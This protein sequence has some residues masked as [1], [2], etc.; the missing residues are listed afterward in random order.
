[1]KELLQKIAADAKAAAKCIEEE[2][3]EDWVNKLLDIAKTAEEELEK[4]DDEPADESDN[5]WEAVDV[6]KT[7]EAAVETALKKYVD[8]YITA[9]D[10][11][12]LLKDLMDAF[13][14]EVTKSVKEE[15]KAVA[16]EVKV[17][18]ERVEK[19]ENEKPSKQ[20]DKTN[21]DDDDKPKGIS[22]IFGWDVLNPYSK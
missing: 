17:V 9:S 5:K 18:S 16:N 21:D 20:L 14:T 6:T 13:K 7:V 15:V 11:K 19:I 2:K 4:Q 8:L 10:V 1:M 22:K 12:Q 3:M